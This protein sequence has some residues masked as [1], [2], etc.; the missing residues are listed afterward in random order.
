MGDMKCNED[1][2]NPSYIEKN[3]KRRPKHDPTNGKK[4]TE[5]SNEDGQTIKDTK[6]YESELFVIGKKDQKYK[7]NNTQKSEFI[8]LIH[9]ST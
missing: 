2:I 1:T 3:N 6:T 7:E 9:L 5:G 8:S 4:R